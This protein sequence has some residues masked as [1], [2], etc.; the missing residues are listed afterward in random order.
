MNKSYTDIKC[1]E[2]SNFAYK[3]EKSIEKMCEKHVYY[4]GRRNLNFFFIFKNTCS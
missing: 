1:K 2:H 3:H 4:F